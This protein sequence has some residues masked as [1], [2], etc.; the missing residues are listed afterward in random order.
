MFRKLREKLGGGKSEEKEEK[1]GK[2]SALPQAVKDKIT[3]VLVGSE[4][5]NKSSY[6]NGLTAGE[7][8]SFIPTVGIDFKSIKYN[9]KTFHVY[10][11][12]GQE[13]FGHLTAVY[14]RMGDIFLLCPTKTGQ[15]S[16]ILKAIGE[17]KQKNVLVVLDRTLGADHV[18]GIKNEVTQLGLQ[19][20]EVPTAENR[21][22]IFDEII[23]VLIS[24]PEQR[25]AMEAKE[26]AE[27]PQRRQAVSEFFANKGNKDSINII[28]DYV[29]DSKDDNSPKPPGGP[30]KS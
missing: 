4:A 15:L 1:L 5:G 7:F 11:T 13:R 24:T 14:Q 12:A 23:R 6:V 10:D 20:I 16:H 8:F 9:N 26:L 25:A 18:E 22:E 30:G 27:G 28:N 19:R 17:D 2:Q 29:S 3:I 21:A